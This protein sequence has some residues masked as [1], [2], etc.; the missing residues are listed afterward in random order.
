MC[1][2]CVVSCKLPQRTEACKG[3]SIGTPLRAYLKSVFSR[4]CGCQLKMLSILGEAGLMAPADVASKAAEALQPF[5]AHPQ[6]LNTLT[7]AACSLP[8]ASSSGQQIRISACN[9]P[10]V[11]VPAL[12]AANTAPAAAT[13]AVPTVFGCPRAPAACANLAAAF[14]SLSAWMGRGSAAAAAAAA[15]SGGGRS[16]A[17]R[18]TGIFC[19]VQRD[20][21]PPYGRLCGSGLR[22]SLQLTQGEMRACVPNWDGAGSGG[23]NH[24]LHGSYSIVYISNAP[25]LHVSCFH[26]LHPCIC[27]CAR[28]RDVF[29][30]PSSTW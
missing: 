6:D 24:H 17:H 3:L 1:S 27:A 9:S 28:A 16:A 15:A 26:I 25:L 10:D 14:L 30:R 23:A 4:F 12:D 19:W 29:C 20:C 7:V 8:A 21:P 18:S 11:P 13:T 5:I 2:I 22:C